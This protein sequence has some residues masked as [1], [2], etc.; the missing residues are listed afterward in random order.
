MEGIEAKVDARVKDQR[1][2]NL[3]SGGTGSGWKEVD[4]AEESFCSSKYPLHS[5]ETSKAVVI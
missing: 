4:L 2:G 3:R 5:A 1:P